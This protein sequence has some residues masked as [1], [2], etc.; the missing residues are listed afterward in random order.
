MA[1]LGCFATRIFGTGGTTRITTGPVGSALVISAHGGLPE[2]VERAA[3]LHL[4][5]DALLRAVRYANTL[6]S[7]DEADL[8]S[9]A[10]L[11]ARYAEWGVIAETFDAWMAQAIEAVR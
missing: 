10:D 1:S 6:R 5:R 2:S 8:S 3:L 4:H 9:F 7:G 11:R